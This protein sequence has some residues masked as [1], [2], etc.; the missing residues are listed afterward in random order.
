MTWHTGILTTDCQGLASDSCLPATP[1]YCTIITFFDITLPPRRFHAV[2]YYLLPEIHDKTYIYLV[3]F[4][5]HNFVDKP[6][7]NSEKN[8]S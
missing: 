5:N 1:D 6:E 7:G 3:H 2:L 4:A 8:I